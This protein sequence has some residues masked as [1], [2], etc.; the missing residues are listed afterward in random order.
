MTTLVKPMVGQKP[1][2][3]PGRT[4]I[5][6]VLAGKKLGRASSQ[7]DRTRRDLYQEQLRGYGNLPNATYPRC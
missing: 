3:S 4:G 6:A 7:R 5:W 2:Q 1:S